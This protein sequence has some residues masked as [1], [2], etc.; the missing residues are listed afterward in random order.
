MFRRAGGINFIGKIISALDDQRRAVTLGEAIL[1]GSDY[2]VIGRPI[3]EAKDPLKVAN[4]IVEELR[5]VSV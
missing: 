1:A 5:K 2:I 4:E 3:L